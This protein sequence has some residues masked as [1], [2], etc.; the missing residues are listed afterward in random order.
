MDFLKNDKTEQRPASAADNSVVAACTQRAVVAVAGDHMFRNGKQN[1]YFVVN[2]DPADD[3]IQRFVFEHFEK[4]AH[5]RRQFGC[6]AVR[7]T[8]TNQQS[9][10]RSAQRTT[11]VEHWHRKKMLRRRMIVWDFFGVPTHPQASVRAT[12]AR[13]DPQ[14][15]DNRT[16]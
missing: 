7:T 6:Q 5:K 16:R 13:A 12:P 14:R 3:V 1:F 15:P 11:H 8:E 2:V 9:A 4:R 10:C